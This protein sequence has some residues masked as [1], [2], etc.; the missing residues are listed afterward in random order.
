MANDQ[1]L[2]TPDILLPSVKKNWQP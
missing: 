1:I 2:Q